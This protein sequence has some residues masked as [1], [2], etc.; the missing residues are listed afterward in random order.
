MLLCWASLEMLLSQEE[1]LFRGRVLFLVWGTLQLFCKVKEESRL[2]LSRFGYCV[3]G[4]Y[5]QFHSPLRHFGSHHCLLRRQHSHRNYE[6]NLYSPDRFHDLHQLL[7][8]ELVFL[9][10][11]TILVSFGRLLRV[12]IFFVFFVFVWWSRIVVL[13]IWALWIFPMF[14][15]FIEFPSRMGGVSARSTILSVVSIGVSAIWAVVSLLVVF[16]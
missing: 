13:S 6:W 10:I 15:I 5:I 12:V 2:V 14:V 3:L 11:R 1:N 7:L 9:V 4:S 8:G 16:F